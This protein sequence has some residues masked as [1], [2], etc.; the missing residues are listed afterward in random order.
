GALCEVGE[1]I[2]RLVAVSGF[3]RGGRHDL[4]LF[5][6]LTDEATSTTCGVV[7]LVEAWV[8]Q[9]PKAGLPVEVKTELQRCTSNVVRSVGEPAHDATADLGALLDLSLHPAIACEV[10]DARQQAMPEALWSVHGARRRVVLLLH[11]R[12]GAGVV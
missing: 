5:R 12:L 9:F 1:R 7:A 10:S 8:G 6:I 11:H 2:V 4:G 3:H